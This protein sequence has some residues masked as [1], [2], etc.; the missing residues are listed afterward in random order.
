MKKN[1]V[2]YLIKRKRDGFK[3]ESVQR[4]L[5]I[6]PFLW[7]HP[8]CGF[9]DEGKLPISLIPSSN[10]NIPKNFAICGQF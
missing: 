1:A 3:S 2:L 6:R 10:V 9:F 4:T 8:S 7:V 5:G